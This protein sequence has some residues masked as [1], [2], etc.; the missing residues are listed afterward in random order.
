MKKKQFA[1]MTG[2]K[3]VLTILRHYQVP[4]VFQ[5]VIDAGYVGADCFAG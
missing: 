4:F 1:E 5:V 2:R 3:I